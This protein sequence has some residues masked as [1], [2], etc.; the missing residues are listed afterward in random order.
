MSQNSA[1]VTELLHLLQSEEALYRDLATL[2]ERE[3]LLIATRDS[4]AL[5][6]NISEQ[7]RLTDQ[8]A[9]FERGRLSLVQVITG[10]QATTIESLASMLPEDLANQVMDMRRRLLQ[11]VLSIELANQRN[12][13]LLIAMRDLVKDRLH[14]VERGRTTYTAVGGRVQAI[15]G[16]SSSGG[17]QA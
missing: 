3:Y 1:A 8:A 13:S 11:I 14:R 9:I 16:R 7:E 5:R 12:T 17:W 15:A 2:A 10:D 6:Q 4:M